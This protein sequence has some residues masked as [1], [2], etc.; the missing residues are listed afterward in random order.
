MNPLQPVSVEIQ[1]AAMKDCDDLLKALEKAGYLD[2]DWWIE[3]DH[4]GGLSGAEHITQTAFRVA[5]SLQQESVLRCLVMMIEKSGCESVSLDFL[6]D[7]DIGLLVES[8][9]DPVIAERLGRERR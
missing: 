5:R 8:G 2:T 1:S 4:G 6:K 9:G 3:R 7:V